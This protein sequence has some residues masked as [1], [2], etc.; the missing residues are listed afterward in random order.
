MLS[1]WLSQFLVQLFQDLL[2]YGH[3]MMPRIIAAF[4]RMLFGLTS[5]IKIPE[6]GSRRCVKDT[7][8]ERAA[9][10][11]CNFQT[12]TIN[13]SLLG[14]SKECSKFLW[15]EASSLTGQFEPSRLIEMG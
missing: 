1:E 12:T 8:M 5:S 11:L 6:A 13:V 3:L 14:S 15:S 7:S 2:V 10:R 4:M 9:L